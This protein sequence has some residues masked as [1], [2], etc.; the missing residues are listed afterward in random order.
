MAKY[1][2]L[3]PWALGVAVLAHACA[4]ATDLIDG[5]DD[6]H[7]ATNA[8]PQLTMTPQGTDGS[9]IGLLRLQDGDLVISSEASGVRYAFQAPGGAR[10][11]SLTLDELK[12]RAPDLYDTVRSATAA[13]GTFLDARVER[14]F[15]PRK[16]SLHEERP[17]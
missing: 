6:A 12:V 15:V 16:P 11:A 14:A 3:A 4:S 7:A 8:Q 13:A 2:G 5:N 10:G 9:V 17:R 1:R